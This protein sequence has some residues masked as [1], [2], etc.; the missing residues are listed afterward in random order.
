MHLKTWSD[1]DGARLYELLRVRVKGGWKRVKC[2][3]L[4][5]GNGDYAACSF[6]FIIFFYFISCFIRII[7][8]IF[9]FLDLPSEFSPIFQSQKSLRGVG[10]GE[11][12]KKVQKVQKKRTRSLPPSIHKGGKRH[13]GRNA[14]YTTCFAS[15]LTPAL[16]V[17]LLASCF[18]LS[19]RKQPRIGR[20]M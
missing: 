11:R 1:A 19:D 5:R 16:P 14:I 12:C 9:F 17:L 6:I 8:I 3:C 10:R 4:F 13:H 18:L 15:L 2:V 20:R 7:S